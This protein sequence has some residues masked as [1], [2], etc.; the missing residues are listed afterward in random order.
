M[1]AGGLTIS[2]EL[3]AGVFKKC[4][5]YSNLAAIPKGVKS[6]CSTISR[7]PGGWSQEHT[8]PGKKEYSTRPAIYRDLRK[9]P[10]ERPIDDLYDC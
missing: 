1:G 6:V 4:S 10:H 3:Y 2:E 5:V 8:S 9:V 7:F